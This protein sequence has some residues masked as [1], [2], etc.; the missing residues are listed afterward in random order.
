VN[1][2][3]NCGVSKMG[4]TADRIGSEATDPQ[5]EQNRNTLSLKEYRT[6]STRYRNRGKKI[7]EKG[8]KR[9]KADN[10]TIK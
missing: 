6:S 3:E 10:E 5:Q 9:P 7:N 4:S 1:E 2:K 8:R